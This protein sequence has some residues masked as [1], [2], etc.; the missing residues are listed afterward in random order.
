[1]STLATL[2]NEFLA[3]LMSGDTMISKRITTVGLVNPFIRLGIYYDAYRSRLTDALALDF[4]ALKCS[5]GEEEFNTMVCDFVR[6]NPSH[7]RNLRWY[8]DGLPQFLRATLPYR[9]SPWIGELA[10]F[11]WSITLAF[12]APDEPHLKF[13]DLAMVDVETWPFLI[14]KLHPSI[15]RLNLRSN[16]VAIRTTVDAGGIPPQPD[17]EWVA[18]PWLVWR[19]DLDVKFRCLSALEARILDGARCG[20]TFG[21]LCEDVSE[22]VRPDQAATTIAGTVRGWVDDQLVTTAKRSPR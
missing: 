2:Q 5:L 16:A 15:H 17:Y 8:G 3:Y 20:K 21:E 9:D 14:L 6:I 19:Q 13:A 22:L 18:A 10:Q 7:F 12:D 1:M 4:V 11:E